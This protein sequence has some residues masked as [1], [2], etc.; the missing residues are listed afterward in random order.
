[1]IGSGARAAAAG[2][3]RE[4][5]M[6]AQ[7]NLTT[8]LA[9][10]LGV[11]IGS[12]KLEAIALAGMAAGVA[13]A[14]SMGGVLYTATR[15]EHDLERNGGGARGSAGALKDPLVAASV[16]FAAAVV[17]AAVPLAPF[18]VLPVRWATAAAAAL[19]VTCLFLLGWWAGGVTGQRRLRA[20]A[21]FVTIGGFA[22]LAS[23]LVGAL[24]RTTGA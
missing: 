20:G 23:A 15:A 12:G 8:V 18:A 22:A 13:E 5:I 7:D 10:V 9:V 24:L 3:L 6:G 11:A 2:S 4:I 17:A 21:R 1:M 16:T 19:S 14:V